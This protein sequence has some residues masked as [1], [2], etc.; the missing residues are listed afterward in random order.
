[1]LTIQPTGITNNNFSKHP[2]F[3]GEDN[4]LDEQTYNK[5]KFY[6]AN[7]KNECDKILN[8]QYVPDGMK[9]GVKICKVASEGILEGW[10]VTWAATEGAKFAKSS[11]L[12]AINSKF[13][14]STAK[15]MKPLKTG[16]QHSARNIGK[17][18]T[19]GIEN[20]KKSNF[21]TKVADKIDKAEKSLN[22]SAPGRLVVKFISGIGKCFKALGNVISTVT[23]KL[24]QPFKKLT[25]DKAAKA[26]AATLG[27][28]SG[29]A[30][31]YNAAREEII[32]DKAVKSNNNTSKNK[33]DDYADEIDNIQEQ[34]VEDAE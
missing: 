27:V 25:Y 18:F 28:G 6:Y 32:K 4:I 34:L 11:V 13:A 1:M 10:A 16:I 29:A 7:Q 19:K 14:K 2:V 21:V 12:K 30:G 31:A 24:V 5:K 8:D 15:A 33:A 26:T 22:K 20:F 3:K 9:K 17:S 23:H